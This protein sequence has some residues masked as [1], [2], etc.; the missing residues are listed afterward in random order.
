MTVGVPVESDSKTVMRADRNVRPTLTSVSG[1][2]SGEIECKSGGM[3]ENERRL[4]CLSGIETCMA[5]GDA[6]MLQ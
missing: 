1:Y 5:R 4:C 3:Y 2:D 6:P